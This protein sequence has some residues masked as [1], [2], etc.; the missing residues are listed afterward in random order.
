MF[1][2]RL[3]PMQTHCMQKRRKALHDTQDKDREREPDTKHNKHSD[4]PENAGRSVGEHTLKSHAP[5]DLTELGMRKGEG[6]KTKVGGRVGN[7][8]K[9][10]LDSVNDL[11]DGNLAKLEALERHVQ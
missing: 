2:V 4:G 9:A 7:A 3:D 5:Q 8:A 11:V 1:S 6:P 10:E